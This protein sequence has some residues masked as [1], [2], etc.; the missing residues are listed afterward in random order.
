VAGATVKL[1]GPATLETET[2]E[3]GKYIVGPVPFGTY[4]V[5]AVFPGLKAVQAIRVEASEVSVLLELKPAEVTTS[6]V[7]KAD[8]AETKDPAP[9]ET[10]SEKTLRDA[11]NVNER[12]ESSLPLIPGVVRGPDGRVNLKGARNTQSG[13]LVNS[14]NVTD[15]VT[16]G[17]AINLP[18]D[19]VA[20][21]Q[22]ISNPMIRSTAS[23]QE[24]FPLSL[25]RRATMKSFTSR[26]RT[27][28]PTA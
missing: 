12:F 1:R 4:T 2:D 3:N 17:P 15:P 7:V 23:S 5:E 11:P 25:Q 19:V 10:I 26:C 21:V 27:L 14:A 20:S 6:V 18:I 24:R 22:V 8:P 9:S 28:F 13:A 16:G